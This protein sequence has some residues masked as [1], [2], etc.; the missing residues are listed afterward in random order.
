MNLKMF[1]RIMVVQ[2]NCVVTPGSSLISFRNLKE[3]KL[4]KKSKLQRA[5]IVLLL[6]I[7]GKCS[8]ESRS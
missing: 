6:L 1:A 7:S 3:E 8:T 4:S 5:L 2:E